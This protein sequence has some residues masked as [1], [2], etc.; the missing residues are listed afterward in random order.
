MLCQNRNR[1]EPLKFANQ[2][3]ICSKAKNATNPGMK[4]RPNLFF[5]PGP[6][7]GDQDQK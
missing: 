6:K 2:R 1:I 4:A 7:C 5:T 3:L